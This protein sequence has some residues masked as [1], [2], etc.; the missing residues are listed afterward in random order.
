M[1]F[2]KK[3][4]DCTWYRHYLLKTS[5][6]VVR[7]RNKY[8]KYFNWAGEN[9]NKNFIN[10]LLLASDH[11][12]SSFSKTARYMHFVIFVSN[13][14]LNAVLCNVRTCKYACETS[15]ACARGPRILI[16]VPN[17]DS[18]VVLCIP[19]IQWNSSK[20]PYL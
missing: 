15:L 14:Y 20:Q 16:F 4:E 9:T 5:P 3:C 7:L 12:I 10:R 6:C 1:T 11:L 17:P 18:N 13:P 8:S 2:M 19:S